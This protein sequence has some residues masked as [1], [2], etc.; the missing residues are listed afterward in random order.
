MKIGK[1]IEAKIDNLVLRT[2]NNLKNKF[3]RATRFKE[4]FSKN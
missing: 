2:S 1:K 4:I 3:P